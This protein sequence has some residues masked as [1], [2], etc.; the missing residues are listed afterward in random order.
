[1]RAARHRRQ[2]TVASLTTQKHIADS[3]LAHLQAKVGHLR[4]QPL[5]RLFIQRAIR[6]ARYALLARRKF[7]QSCQ[8]LSHALF[9][10]FFHNYK[11]PSS[12]QRNIM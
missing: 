8:K 10:Y 5:L 2:R 9:I 12:C 3:V 6:K 4:Q 11:P 7:C 1:M